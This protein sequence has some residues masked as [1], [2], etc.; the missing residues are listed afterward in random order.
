MGKKKKEEAGVNERQTAEEVEH[1]PLS[2]PFG[3]SKMRMVRLMFC[4]LLKG[5]GPCG[6]S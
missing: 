1:Y 3:R 6:L 5:Q 4:W 2:I